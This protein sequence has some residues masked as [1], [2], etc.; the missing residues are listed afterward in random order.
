MRKP[1]LF[2]SAAVLVISASAVPAQNPV[3][4]LDPRLVA[5]AQKDHEDGRETY[6]HSLL[7]DPWGTILADMGETNG[8]AFGEIDL[9]KVAE[10]RSRV[11][12]IRHRRPIGDAVTR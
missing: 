4:Q 12:A 10:V 1:L 5:E 7:V 9:A 3:R 11:P 6:G 2:L 8:V